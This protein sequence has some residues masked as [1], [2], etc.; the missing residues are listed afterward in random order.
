MTKSIALCVALPAILLAQPQTAA[1]DRPAFEVASVK[2]HLPSPGPMRVSRSAENGRINF[3]NMTLQGCIRAAYGLQGYQ[4]L[5]GPEWTA[6]ERFDIVAKAAGRAT[7]AQ[8]LP[9]LQTLLADRFKLIVRRE[10][11]DLPTYD[12]V[13]AKNGPKI[14]PVKDDENGTQIDGDDQHPITARNVSMKQ[15]AGI[16]TH[17]Q[18]TDRPVFDQTG[19]QGVFSFSLSFARDDASGDAPDIFSALQEQ[20]GLKLIPSRRPTEVLV[21]EHAEKPTAN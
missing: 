5:G 13:V 1:V 7:E 17:E 3:V 16:L 4:L 18:Q 15:L 20:L 12:L 19:I 6:S 9:M 21:I 14:H 11:K 10:I 8:M 2:T